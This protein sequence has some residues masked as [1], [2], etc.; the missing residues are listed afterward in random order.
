MTLSFFLILLSFFLYGALHS[1]LASHS[2]KRWACRAG[3]SLAQRWYRLAYNLVGAVT[4][5][6]VLALTALLPDRP[7]YAFPGALRWAGYALQGTAL[8]LFAAALLQTDLGAFSGLAQ[9]RGQDD[10]LCS[11]DARGRGGS[12]VTS[13]LYR[14]VRHPLYTSGLLFLWANPVVSWNGLAFNL[15]ASAYLVIGALFE[16]RKLL[17][18]F[19]PAYAEYRRR[20][21]MLIPLP[22][23]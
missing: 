17:A 18:E 23:R 2:V 8:L 11:P 4:F 16:E 22:R 5:L 10:S 1:L 14:L 7:L 6:P 19:G 13:G 3:G 9:L 21:P 20:T 12:L 15:G